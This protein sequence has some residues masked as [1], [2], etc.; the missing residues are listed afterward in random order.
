MLHI[1]Y[2]EDIPLVGILYDIIEDMH[3]IRDTSPLFS[4]TTAA[5]LLGLHPRT[6]MLYEYEELLIPRRSATNRRVYSMKDLKEI[7]FIRYLLRMKK[8]NYAGVRIVLRMLD[9]A[10]EKGVEL[11]NSMF[12]DFKE[13]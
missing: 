1:L 6:L 7:K 10:D 8:L 5:D 12:R 2:L 9:K 11:R 4:I 13:D 3:E